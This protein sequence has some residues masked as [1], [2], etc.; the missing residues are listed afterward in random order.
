MNLYI[1]DGK[2]V[3]VLSAGRRALADTRRGSY[4]NSQTALLPGRHFYFVSDGFLDQAGGETG[5]GF[6]DRRFTDMI[7][8]FAHL[9]LREQINAFRATLEAYQG[10]TAQRDD[11]TLLCF[12]CGQDAEAE[13][14]HDAI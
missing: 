14:H 3:E 7:L 2:Q 13:G 8:R 4:V 12:T 11:I 9:P 5:F 6:G 1:S 10:N